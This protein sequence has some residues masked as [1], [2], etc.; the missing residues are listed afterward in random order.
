MVAHFSRGHPQRGPSCSSLVT[1]GG[2]KPLFSKRG[3]LQIMV[4]TPSQPKLFLFAVTQSL[5][6]P[7][8]S[9]LPHSSLPVN[10]PLTMLFE[11]SRLRPLNLPSSPRW[12]DFCKIQA[13]AVPPLLN[14]HE[15]EQT[16]GDGE[17]Q[18]SQ[19][20]CSPWGH[21]EL[22]TTERLNSSYLR[23]PRSCL[24]SLLL[25]V[26]LRAP[27]D[28]ALPCFLTPS[29]L[30]DQNPWLAG[31]GRLRRPC[32]GRSCFLSTWLTSLSAPSRHSQKS[33]PWKTFPWPPLWRMR[34]A[35]GP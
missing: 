4:S 34:M 12:R 29:N 18:G 15:F 21:K 33:P 11:A 26:V 30:L 17:G 2:V 19:A 1:P 32:F 9:Y 6:F 5:V 10:P 24:K 16:P 7:L 22:D 14:G 35:S 23:P 13:L 25:G 3:V 28:P 27:P 20:C 31:P 8:K